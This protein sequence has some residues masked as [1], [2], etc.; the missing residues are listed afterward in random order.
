FG[1]APPPDNQDTLLD[2]LSSLL[3]KNFLLVESSASGNPRFRML[4]TIREFG[5][6]Q[7]RGEDAEL[8][9]RLRH[10]HYYARTAPTEVDLAGSRQALFLGQIDEDIANIRFAMQTALDVGGEAVSQ[11]LVLAS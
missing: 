3:D 2:D 11:G 6:E 1:N 8:E 7:V 10:L 4:E 5:M 9:L